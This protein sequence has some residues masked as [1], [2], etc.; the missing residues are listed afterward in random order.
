MLFLSTPVILIRR[1]KNPKNVFSK[2]VRTGCKVSG[3]FLEGEALGKYSSGY[4]GKVYASTYILFCV[5][6]HSEC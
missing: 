4:F 3:A 6:S 5:R 2:D 1:G